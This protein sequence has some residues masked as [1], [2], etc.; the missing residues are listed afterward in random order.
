MYRHHQQAVTA[1]AAAPGPG[2]QF[3][4][5]NTAMHQWYAA[6]YHHQGAQMGGA[7]PASYCMQDEQQM[8]H[9]HAHS[10]AAAAAHSAFP[11]FPDYVHMPQIHH[12]HDLNGENQLPSPPITVSGGS[13]NMSSPGAGSG[14]LSP[15]SPQPQQ[16][17][18]QQQQVG[19]R[20][21]PARSPYEW[22]KKTSYQ[23]QPNPGR[24]LIYFYIGTSCCFLV[25]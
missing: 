16:H 25:T 6:G 9:H 21:P 3:H 17:H 1:S 4:A 19:S 20:P 18:H 14:H 10:A 12:Q 7:P 15:H 13:D 11:D 22:I 23:T 24:C 8:W 2:H 5:A